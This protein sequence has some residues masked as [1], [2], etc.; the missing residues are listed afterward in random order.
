MCPADFNDM[1]KSLGLFL[2]GITKLGK[3]W[4]Q[5]M[6]YLSHSGYMH[7]RGESAKVL[8]PLIKY[9]T[10]CDI[11][12]VAALAHVDM[13][14]GMNRLLGALLASQNLNCTI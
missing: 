13:I 11:R 6:A 3:S 14:I 2:K 9:H 4:N 8:S 5:V 12:I 7:C 1:F 10:K